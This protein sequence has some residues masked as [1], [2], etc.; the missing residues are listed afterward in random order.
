[1]NHKKFVPLLIIFSCII[2]LVKCGFETTPT[3][4][5][6]HVLPTPQPTPGFI[7]DLSPKPSEIILFD[8]FLTGKSQTVGQLGLDLSGRP[9]VCIKYNFT[10]FDSQN[11]SLVKYMT[12]LIDGFSVSRIGSL[13]LE[14][15]VCISC[16]NVRRCWEARF[17]SGIHEVVFQ[18][19]LKSG[20]VEE[21]TWYY[22]I[23]ESV[24]TPTSRPE[25]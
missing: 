20:E 2:A 11:T 24:A 7:R 15:N 25:P 9:T 8:L 14:S 22:E 1:M 6:D 17:D 12:L 16:D 21:Y 23:V 19:H 4:E 5:S 10:S 13:V 18:L 3:F